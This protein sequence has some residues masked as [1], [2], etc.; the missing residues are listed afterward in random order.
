LCLNGFPLE[1][2]PHHDAG[3]EW[4][5]ITGMTDNGGIFFLLL[6]SISVKLDD[7]MIDKLREKLS[8][9][10]LENEP[11]AN[12]CTFRIGGPARYFFIAKGAEEIVKAVRIARD[13]QTP[14]FIF[15]GGS[16]ILFSDKGFDGLAVKIASS[17]YKVVSDGLV[18]ADAG[19]KLADVVAAAA[20]KGLTGL[21]WA[22]GIPG[23]VGGAVRGNAGA[24]G[25]ATG[26]AVESVEALQIEDLR[27]KIKNYSQKNCEFGYRDSIFKHNSN[28][29]LKVVLKLQK[30]AKEKIKTEVERII[31]ERNQKLPLE[32]PSTGCVLK[33]VEITDAVLKSFRAHS[34]EEIPADFIEKGKIPAAW[35]VERCD[36]KEKKI[37]GAKISEKHANFLVNNNKATA[38][39][40]VALIGLIKMKVRD[41]LGVQ[42]QEEIEYVGF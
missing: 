27:F 42:L 15:G 39:D 14:F 10:V 4:Q 36:L 11:L 37:G 35:L 31:K 19:V 38:S 17:K 2:T 3:R 12:H 26:E 5:K 1:F 41:E 33:N 40:V 24:Y 29:I 34:S 18:E 6:P 9:E 22:A 21:E 7:V 28:I 32:Y 8:G 16:N 23:T 30:G 20:E 25:K 13:L